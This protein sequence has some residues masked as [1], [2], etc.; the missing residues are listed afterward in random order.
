MLNYIAIAEHCNGQA[1]Q[2]DPTDGW[3]PVISAASIDEA[4]RLAK[5]D[6]ARDGGS[7]Y[8]DVWWDSVEIAL[9]PADVATAEATASSDPD[10][11]DTW[12]YWRSYLPPEVADWLSRQD[13]HD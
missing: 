9:L 10:A 8:G 3:S 12:R 11:I 2:N 7:D 5:D 6:L 13:R 4:K 1:K